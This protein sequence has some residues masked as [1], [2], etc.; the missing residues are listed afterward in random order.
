MNRK[1]S[2]LLLFLLFSIKLLLLTS[3]AGIIPP[4]GGPKDTIPPRLVM[5]LPLDSATNVKGQ[6]LVL[7]FDEFVEVK[8]VSQNVLVSPYPIKSPIIE[9]NLRKVTVKLRDSLQPNTTYSINFGNSI[10]DINEGNMYKNFTYVFSTGARLATG[11]FAGKVI[12]AETG[13]VDST[14][15]VVLHR[16]LNDTAIYKSDPR[17]IAKIDGKGGFTF[18]FIETGKYNA[19]VVPNEYSKKY[20]DSTKVFAFLDSAI[21]IDN[22]TEPAVFYAYQEEK[23]KEKAKRSS[24]SGSSKEDTKKEDKYL[25][26]ATSLE[27]GRSQD[28][29]NKLKITF[30]KP[31]QY[32][33]SS[34]VALYDTFYNPITNAEIKLDTGKTFATINYKWK[35]G[36]AFYLIIPKDVAKD[37]S[38]NVLKKGDTLTFYTKNES[39]Y[40]SVKIKFLNLDL[41]L[42]PV[43]QIISGDKI[44]ESVPLTATVFYRKLYKPSDYV[45]RILYD[46]NQNGVWDAGNYKNRKQ[47]EVVLDKDWK[48]NVKANWDN[49][50]EIKL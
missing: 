16:N 34:K 4:N 37:T 11:Q 10:R 41:K 12:M 20:D 26:Y 47:P 7:T 48:L 13:K 17:Y 5:A 50:T 8:D 29:L 33:D 28:L 44:E 49:E 23:K 9:A 30:S 1:L 39:E 25:K 45:V 24:S 43:L 46:A 40:G 21:T 36:N 18:N 2:S 31:L 42:H 35:E 3:C 14:L 19:F 6:K 32:F 22:E 15:L 27:G 38:G